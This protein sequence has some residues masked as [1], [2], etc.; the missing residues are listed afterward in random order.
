MARGR[1]SRPYKTPEGWRFM[2][3][4]RFYRAPTESA[5][6]LRLAEVQRGAVPEQRRSVAPVTI[7]ELVDRWEDE[8]ERS[9]GTPPAYQAYILDRFVA[10]GGT[11]RLD[12]V[13]VGMLSDYLAHLRSAKSIRGKAL[14][15]ETLCKHVKQ[16]SAVLGWGHRR[17]WLKLK[18]DIPRLPSVPFRPKALTRGELDTLL[19]SLAA[20]SRSKHFMPVTRFLL[21][22]GCRVGEAVVA[23]WADIDMTRRVWTIPRHKSIGRQSAPSVRTVPLST[24]AVSILA[25]VATACGS[26]PDRHL[27]QSY[28]GTPYTVAGFAS[29]IKRHG[30]N[31]HRLRHT[32]C[33]FAADAG[34]RPEVMSDIMGHSSSQMIRHYCR[35][36]DERRLA[37]VALTDGLSRL[38]LTPCLVSQASEQPRVSKGTRVR[39]AQK[40]GSQQDTGR[41][42]QRA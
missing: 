14:K 1:P 38:P 19:A 42:R 20:S 35:V 6:W 32:W 29:I 11:E 30:V 41:R 3:R 16:A 37:A 23:K 26:E 2:Y 12:G 31:V 8:R 40:T 36:A 22:T 10:W 5:A 28:A 7:A 24:T 9:E 33:Q 25:D 17:G 18:P 4:G 15:D 34:V 27:F 39:L 13:G 21:E